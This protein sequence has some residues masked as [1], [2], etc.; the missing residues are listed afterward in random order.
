M[1]VGADESGCSCSLGEQI[2]DCPARKGEQSLM[3]Y[4][5]IGLAAY[6]YSLDSMTT[7]QYLYYA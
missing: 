5:S 7:Y 6:I 4:H 1:V 3:T 2:M